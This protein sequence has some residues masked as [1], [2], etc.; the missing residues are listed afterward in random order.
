MVGLLFGLLQILPEQR[1]DQWAFLV[2]RPVPR[3][4]IFGGKVIA[5]LLLYLLAT[6]LPAVIT[7]AWRAMPGHIPAPFD[8]R[9]ALPGLADILTGTAYYFAGL[10]I[11]LRPA[12]WYGSRVLPLPAAVIC[13]FMV[14]AASEFWQALRRSLSRCYHGS[15]RLGKFRTSGDYGSQTKAAK[16]GLATILYAGV[17][18]VVWAL[19]D[20]SCRFSAAISRLLKR[21]IH[22]MASRRRAGAACDQ[23]RQ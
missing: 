10:L 3:D 17:V 8:M 9:L 2:H 7:L 5:G 4:V 20:C 6:L 15:G 1:R 11:A 13:S 18:V 16:A 22:S 14:I 23:S 12:R 21:P 19:L